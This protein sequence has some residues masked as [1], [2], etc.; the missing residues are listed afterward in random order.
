MHRGN[1]GREL[2]EECLLINERYRG[3][4]HPSMAT[5]LINLAAS[6]S[7]SKNYVEAERLLRTCL[8]IMEKSVSSEDQ[9][10]TFPMLNLAVTLSQLNRDE[11][12][13]QIALKVLRI[14]ENAFGKDTLPVGIYKIFS[15][16]H[17]I[18]NLYEISCW[19]FVI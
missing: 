14:R 19:V 10:I 2:L 16:L 15:S 5:H 13:E 8:D 11:E 7:R 17:N 4:N 12:A 18:I 1:E 6:Y 9:S 3:K